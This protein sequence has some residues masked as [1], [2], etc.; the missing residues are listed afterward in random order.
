MRLQNIPV[1][2]KKPPEIILRHF[3]GEGRLL[4]H[5]SDLLNNLPLGFHACS[6]VEVPTKRHLMLRKS[7]KN[8][9]LPSCPKVTA[10]SAQILEM[11]VWDTHIEKINAQLLCLSYLLK[12]MLSSSHLWNKIFLH[13]TLLPS[14]MC[15]RAYLRLLWKKP[16]SVTARN[17]I[18]N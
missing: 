10:W 9:V 17:Q 5:F 1:H 18:F 16:R 7:K 2:L 4:S 11:S 12:N 3:R 6:F 15:Y 13:N 8:L 14:S